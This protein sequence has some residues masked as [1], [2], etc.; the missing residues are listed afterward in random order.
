MVGVHFVLKFAKVQQASIGR[1][2]EIALLL[3]ESGAVSGYA[4]L[5][6]LAVW[7]SSFVQ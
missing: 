4:K 6:K 1:A 3:P 7:L 5:D 2:N